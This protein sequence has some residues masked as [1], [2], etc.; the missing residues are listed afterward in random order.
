MDIIQIMVF[1]SSML[2]G[3]IVG[4][5]FGK[6]FV[7]ITSNNRFCLTKLGTVIFGKKTGL[8]NQFVNGAK[9]TL[10]V[11]LDLVLISLVTYFIESFVSREVSKHL[12]F[13]FPFTLFVLTLLYTL[14]RKTTKIHLEEWLILAVFY[15]GSLISMYG[16]YQFW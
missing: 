13:Y 5:L 10:L 3:L 7:K 2:C 11:I 9:G 16:L 4:W 14:I 1:I 12:V 6:I 8:S 15:L